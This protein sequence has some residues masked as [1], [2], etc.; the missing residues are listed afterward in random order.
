MKKGLL[1]ASVAIV[2]VSCFQSTKKETTIS[3]PGYNFSEFR[4]ILMNEDLDEISG[5]F[6][7][8]GDS[9][10]VALNDEEG[11]LYRINMLGKL[12]SKAF[13]FAKKSDF[14]DLTF[15]GTYWYAV[16]SNGE[17]TRISNAFTDSFNTR[18]FEFPEKGWEFETIV[19]DN[20]KN[21]IVA[22]SKV[23][24][25]LK[26]G[27][28]PAYTLDTVSGTFN[29]DQYYSPDTTEIRNIVQKKKHEFK[30]TAAAFHPITHELF[31]ISVNDR[32]LVT[33]KDGKLTGAYKLDK[34][35]FRQPE[36][37]CFMPNGNLLISN[38]AQESIANIHIFEYH[39]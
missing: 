35:E 8:P 14:E 24:A 23:P 12:T 15:D 31:I 13:K 25:I 27:K 9:T 3:P 30:P 28:I 11:K 32:M 34:S 36:G 20:Q 19:F 10:I 2:L 1:I 37:I 22:I 33:M 16:K 29:Y 21:K 39:Q 7:I 18:T 17:V 4:K 5:I 38:E 6:F 26:E